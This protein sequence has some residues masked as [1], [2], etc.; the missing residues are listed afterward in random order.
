MDFVFDTFI[1]FVFTMFSTLELKDKVNGIQIRIIREFSSL[2]P[3]PNVCETD[4]QVPK[5]QYVLSL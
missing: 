3:A 2:E 1:V 5:C 4:V